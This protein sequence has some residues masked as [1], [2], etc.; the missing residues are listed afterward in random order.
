[1]SRHEGF[2]NRGSL[3]TS[4]A[5][6]RPAPSPPTFLSACAPR[7]AAAKLP[8]PL[9][10]LSHPRLPLTLLFPPSAPRPQGDIVEGS[11]SE[12]RLAVFVLA[13]KR[14]WSQQKGELSW[15]AMEVAMH[16]SQLYL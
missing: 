6:L 16:G 1:M 8:P 9:G 11:D 7:P 12:I 4:V 15:K 5:K 2:K 13:L 14:E 3:G 10:S